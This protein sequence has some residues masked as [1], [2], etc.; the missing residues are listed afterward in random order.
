MSLEH[1]I[2]KD[3]GTRSIVVERSLLRLYAKAIGEDNP[4][5]LGDEAAIRQG[6]R[7]MLVPPTYLFCLEA[8]AF[9]S[10]GHAV[11]LG[12]DASR[13]L[14]GEQQFMMKLPA[15]AG[16]RLTFSIRVTNAY[17]KK[18]GELDFVEKETSVT[19]ENG[20]HVAHLRSI[21]V[22]RNK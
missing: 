19:N 7:G 15:H 4:I 20:Q 11:L 9:E 1:L 6:H 8:L 3:L 21:I 12:M 2:G 22:Q 18:G 5:Y 10:V 13:L 17:Q 16:E 14:H